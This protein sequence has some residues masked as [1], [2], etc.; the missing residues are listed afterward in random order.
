[1]GAKVEDR[2]KKV[3]TELNEELLLEYFPAERDIVYTP[4][5]QAESGNLPVWRV[6]FEL[7]FDSS[8]RMGLDINGEVV[9]GRSHEEVEAVTLFNAQDAERLG[10]SRQHALLRPTDSKLYIL[11]LDSTNGTWLNGRSIGVNMPYS[12]CDGDYLKLGRMEL[13]VRIIKRPLV[14]TAV[15]RAQDDLA[16][17]LPA[18]GC[19][20]AGQLKHEEVLKQTLN[21][22]ITYTSASEV[23]IWLVDEQ[24]NEL[25]LEAGRGMDDVQIQR[26]PVTDTLPGEVIRTGK[27][28]RMNATTGN[29]PIKV[30]TGYLVGAAI[31]VPLT[32][33]GVTFGVLSAT[34]RQPGRLFNAREEKFMAAL[35]DFTAVAVQNARQYQSAEHTLNRQSKLL[36]GLHYALSNQFKNRLNSALG[37]AG[38]LRS[39]VPLGS[40]ATEITDQIIEAA[41]GLVALIDQLSEIT[42]TDEPGFHHQQTCD[43]VGIVTKALEDLHEKAAARRITLGFQLIGEAYLIQADITRLYRSVLHLVDNAVRYAAVGAQVTVTLVFWDDRIMLRVWNTGS[44]IPDDILPEL[45]NRYYR[46]SLSEGA[47]LGLEYV[48]MAVEAHRGTVSARNIEGQG[49]EFLINLPASLRVM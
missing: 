35:A 29:D 13:V 4:V 15:L 7:A 44:S 30:K 38:L 24:T 17:L 40:E 23:A 6:R 34:H 14:K 21:A 11:D 8:I 20:I 22:A 9:L 45:F 33:G 12:L 47:G 32:L 42:A 49:V 27:P 41:N 39:T 25:F 31:Y 48:R 36:T 28:L 43:F 3:T 10:V 19:I 46:G 1:M 18:V 16:D 26:L 2:I 37:Y 5:P